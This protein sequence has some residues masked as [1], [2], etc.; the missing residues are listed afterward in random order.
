M[1]R[2]A[3]IAITRGGLATARRISS[4]HPSWEVHAPSKLDDGQGGVSWFG[5]PAAG[6]VGGLFA[7]MEAL[8][9]I[10]SLGAVI[11]LVAPHL[12]G[13]KSDPAIVVVDDAG[14]FA[15]SALSGHLGGANELARDIAGGIGAVPVITTAAD[16]T[17]TI[18]VDMVGRD[19]GW[20]IDGDEHVTRVSAMMVNGEAIGVWQGAGERGVLGGGSLPP[21]VTEYAS[22]GELCGSGCAGA[23][24][25][26]DTL[27]AAPPMPAVTYRPRTLIVG[28]GVHRDTPAPKILESLE[29]TLRGASLS[30]MCVAR[31]ASVKKPA[32]VE[33]LAEAAPRAGGSSSCKR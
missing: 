30:P 10:F 13:K 7:S 19:A 25:V 1:E 21:N 14:G 27:D 16:V 4:L 8:V 6:T 15:I 2:V 32:A 26:S 24:V 23:L 9:C 3:V 20:R 18:A 12:R 22:M 31:L 29:G 28:V 17:G 11:R 33:G 5:G